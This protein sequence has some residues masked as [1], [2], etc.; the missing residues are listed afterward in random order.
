MIGDDRSKLIVRHATRKWAANVEPESM[1]QWYAPR[2]L[3]AGVEQHV[4]DE[5]QDLGAVLARILA[6]LGLP[7]DLPSD[8]G[9]LSF[10]R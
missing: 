10:G 3:L 4:F 9:A 5:H 2:D 7:V 8:P 6:D 1:R